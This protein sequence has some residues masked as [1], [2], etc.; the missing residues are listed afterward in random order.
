[1]IRAQSPKS[2]IQ[3]MITQQSMK[4]A[5]EY[6][7]IDEMY[8]IAGGRGFTV[9][10]TGVPYNIQTVWSYLFHQYGLLKYGY[11]PFWEVGN[12]L[13]FP[14]VMPVPKSGSTCLRFLGREPMH[15]LPQV[16]VDNDRGLEKKFSIIVEK[17]SFGSFLLETR[18]SIDIDCHDNRP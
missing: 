10:M 17:K 8:T 15:G 7:M 3:E 9:R 14:G 6:R 16:L 13:A 5:D 4:L 11:L 2:L 18:L 1:M 12:V